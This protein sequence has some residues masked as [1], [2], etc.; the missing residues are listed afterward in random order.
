MKVIAYNRPKQTV[1]DLF[2]KSRIDYNAA[3]LILYSAYNA[4][5]RDVTG[6][7]SDQRALAAIKLKTDLWNTA[8]QDRS[9]PG[10]RSLLRRLYALTNHRPLHGYTSWHGSL[11]DEA[12]WRGLIEFWYALRCAIVHGNDVVGNPYHDIYIKLAYESLFL[13]MNEVVSRQVSQDDDHL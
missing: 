2:M 12:D 3:Y 4:W 13:F 5:Y 1:R 8:L 9:M 6:H 11:D 10:L 7:V